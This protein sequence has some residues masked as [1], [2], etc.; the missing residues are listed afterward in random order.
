MDD[1]ILAYVY[2]S[3]RMM[4]GGLAARGAGSGAGAGQSRVDQVNGGGGKMGHQD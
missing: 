2:V 1:G 3:R 4:V